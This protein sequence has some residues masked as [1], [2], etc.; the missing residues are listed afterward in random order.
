MGGP[1]F[2]TETKVIRIGKKN[3]VTIK[4]NYLSEYDSGPRI[5]TEKPSFSD[6]VEIKLV[7]GDNSL[8]KKINIETI[9]LSNP[10]KDEIHHAI[11]KLVG[12]YRKKL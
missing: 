8:I 9:V 4:I 1:I 11:M 12:V 5:I 6:T 10:S 3:K 7:S 2:K